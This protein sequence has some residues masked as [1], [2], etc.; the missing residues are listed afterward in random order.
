MDYV[1]RPDINL[2]LKM[3]NVDTTCRTCTKNGE[4]LVDIFE[5]WKTRNE[6]SAQLSDFKEILKTFTGTEVIEHQI[7]FVL[8]LLNYVRLLFPCGIARIK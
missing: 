1:Q 7:T 4:N 3:L 8:S 5:P 6:N 2:D